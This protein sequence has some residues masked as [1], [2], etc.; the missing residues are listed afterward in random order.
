LER[1]IRLAVPKAK[2]IDIEV[3]AGTED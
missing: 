2:H 3:D 1:K